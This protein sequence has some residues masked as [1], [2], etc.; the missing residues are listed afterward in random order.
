MVLFTVLAP[1]GQSGNLWVHLH[2]AYRVFLILMSSVFLIV[3]VPCSLYTPAGCIDTSPV[4]SCQFRSMPCFY[5]LR[6]ACQPSSVLE[7]GA[8]FPFQFYNLCI[9]KELSIFRTCQGSHLR[10]GFEGW[11]FSMAVPRDFWVVEFAESAVVIFIA[12][13]EYW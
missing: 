13:C 4:R 11:G 1:G 9:K 3:G 6:I 12:F 8:S 2:T 5:R 7:Y 10:S